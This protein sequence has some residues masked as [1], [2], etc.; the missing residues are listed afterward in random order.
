MKLNSDMIM[1]SLDYA[2]D[3][4]INGVP[5]LDSAIDLGE[6]YKGNYDDIHVASKKLVTWQIAKAGTSGFVTNIGGMITLPVAIPANIASVLYIQTRMI[7]AIAHIGNHDV[8]DDRIKTL[9][10][11]CF[12]GSAITDIAKDAGIKIGVKL[13]EQAIRSISASTIAKINKTVG[14]RLLTKFGSTGVINLGKAVPL[15]GGLI[16]GTFDSV[17]T[18]AVG[19]AAI[20]TFITE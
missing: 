19:V 6:N 12:T 5:G 14:F 1:K 7:A 15:V 3:K 2:Y 16:G 10:Y 11:M 4:A 17:T 8:Y 20:R 13:T 9:C 18:K